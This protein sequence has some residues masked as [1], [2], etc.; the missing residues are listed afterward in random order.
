MQFDPMFVFGAVGLGGL[1]AIARTV[2][3]WAMDSS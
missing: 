3:G 2:L 1:L